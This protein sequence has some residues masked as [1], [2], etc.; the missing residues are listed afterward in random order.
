[1]TADGPTPTPRPGRPGLL[2]AEWRQSRSPMGLPSELNSKLAIHRHPQFIIGP[3]FVTLVGLSVAGSLSQ[4][5]VRGNGMHLLFIWLAWFVLVLRVIWKISQWSTEYFLVTNERI[6]LVSGIVRRR[7]TAIWLA[8]VTAVR[9]RR[10]IGGRFLGYGE[11]VFHSQCP[12]A[13]LI[14]FDYAPYP[15]LLTQEIERLVFRGL[16]D[17]LDT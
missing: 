11:L 7:F 15:Q 5:V 4:N 16:W 8:Q 2:S 14:A 3:I 17:D 10:T 9:V 1:M 12:D 6:I 13:A